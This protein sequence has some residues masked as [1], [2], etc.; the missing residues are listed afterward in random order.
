MIILDKPY[1]SQF[2]LDSV[3]AL[4]I[5]VL[6]NEVA[7]SLPSTG[8]RLLDEAA[9]VAHQQSKPYPEVYCNSENSLNW[10]KQNLAFS[11]LPQ[12]IELFKDKVQFRQLLAPLYPDY[13]FSK[14]AYE[15]LA[16]LDVT[17]LPLPFI[18][19]PA[20]G[21]FSMGVYRVDEA[22][23]WPATVAQ[24]QAEMARIAGLYPPEVMDGGAFIIEQVIE[25]AEFAVDAYFN[26]QG[27]PVILNIL[28]H[29]FSSAHDMSDRLYLTSAEIMQRYYQPFRQILLEMGRLAG[30]RDFP[31]HL[32]LRLSDGN[33]AIPIEANPMRFAGWC[34]TDIAWYAYGI[35][36]YDYYFNQKTPNWDRILA[37]MPADQYGLV[38]A[39]V[40]KH[41]NPA[42]IS[43][44]DYDRFLANFSEPQEIRRI[45]YREYP[46]F[47]FLL[48]KIAEANAAEV[49]KILNLDFADYI[50]LNG[51]SF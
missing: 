10:L 40:P 28:R 36:V 46:V 42:H 26:R 21:F 41:I 13:F 12:K 44:V 22:V 32:E 49:N 33:V 43:A 11:D 39:D 27:Q 50:S 45:D 25:G 14:V 4:D 31:M 2:L 16:A 48:V 7:Q 47:A 5:P 29:E 19:K 17:T 3:T 8:L 51:A 15:D 20:V 9:A 24:I 37:G 1:V 30:L 38:V 6:R 35:N 23:Q 34:T 18:I